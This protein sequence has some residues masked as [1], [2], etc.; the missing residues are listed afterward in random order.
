MCLVLLAS[1]E[2]LSSSVLSCRPSHTHTSTPIHT[3]VMCTVV[4]I[5]PSCRWW[6]YLFFHFYVS[7]LP[8]KSHQGEHRPKDEIVL[9]KGVMLCSNSLGPKSCTITSN[10][11][12]CHN[13]LFLW[14]LSQSNLLLL[15]FTYYMHSFIS[16]ECKPKGREFLLFSGISLCSLVYVNKY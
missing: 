8:L 11:F 3:T 15:K 9:S 2:V 10:A 16:P 1:P 4:Q 5:F 7:H 6:K 14:H 13:I 12:A